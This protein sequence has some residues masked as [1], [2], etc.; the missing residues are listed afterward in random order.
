VSEQATCCEPSA[1]ASCCG[2]TPSK[3]DA[4]VG[5]SCGCR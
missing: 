5:P 4:A 2:T 1:K 3:P